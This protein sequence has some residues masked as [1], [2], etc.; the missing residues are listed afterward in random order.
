[1]A[2]VEVAPTSDEA[3]AIDITDRVAFDAVLAELRE[4]GRL[5][6]VENQP[7]RPARFAKTHEPLSPSIVEALGTEQ[8]W[9]HQAQAIDLI[10]E[11]QSVVV[12]TGT[13]SGK[14]RCYQIPIAEAADRPHHT[15]TALL[16]YPTKAL[17]QDQLRAMA[18][19]KFPG[20][21]AG[22][23]DGDS[24]PEQRSWVRASANVIMTNP[25]ML[26][27]GLL[28]S[29]SRWATFFGRLEHVVIDELH[30]LRGIF[31]THVSHV[32]RRLRRICQ[33]YGSDPTFIFT[34]ATIGAP[35]V[36]ASELC[37]K[38]VQAVTADG[39][40]CGERTIALLNP[41][42]L[43]EARG[44]RT[45]ANA[46]TAS[47]AADLMRSGH[48]TIVFCRSR[49]GTELVTG[50][51]ASRLPADL[52]DAV[53]AYRSGYLAEER[54]TIEH[55]LFDGTL[56]GVVATSALELGVDIGGLDACVLNTFPGTVASMWQQMGRAGRGQQRSAAILVAGDDQLD[57][58]MMANPTDLL[59][60]EPER[61]VINPANPF[62]LGPHLACAAFEKPISHADDEYWG[63]ALDDGIRDLVLDDTITLK[64][65]GT[66]EPVAVYTGSGRPSRGI[67]LRSGSAD[68]YRIAD[69]EGV[70]IGTVDAERAF[71]VVHPGA[72]YLHQGRPYRVTDLDTG[73]RVATVTEADGDEY[74]QARTRVD[75][76]VLE[77]DDSAMLGPASVHLGAVE[78]TSQ[79]TGYQR[80]EVR[81][82]RI[83]SNE[84]LDLPPSTLRTRAFWYVV[85]PQ[86]IEV[87]DI[88]HSAIPGA[89][90]AAEH[91][92]IGMLPLFTI[93]DRWDVGG[94]S[95][96]WHAGT[97]G[98]TIFI[99]DAHPGGSGIAELG[100]A[101]RDRHFLATR[102]AVRSCGCADGCPS[103]VQ[104]PKCG[105]GNEPLDKAGA[106]ALL[107][108][109]L[110]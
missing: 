98:P 28:P 58:W 76:A 41:P 33:H 2:L 52:S 64:P 36:L 45:S 77:A 12:A 29:H 55:E 82:R 19:Y 92:A 23:Y 108:E 102:D 9:T 73:N 47:V 50:D 56:R 46:E 14:S 70:L 38:E 97:G 80:R 104:S 20:V 83:L 37:G 30:V 10:R 86:T 62:V 42:L 90:H 99:Y 32:L 1:M 74:T 60:R 17:A 109:I 39:S 107:D 22:T 105:N 88:D 59:T 25:E 91:A 40:P 69:A 35:E 78:V 5:A 95:T 72:V 84:A 96:A 15:A 11:Q 66:G 100:F 18:A 93:C 87:A 106:V 67:G 101:E 81:S 6:H 34:S 85:P 27:A 26:H 4:D 24:T 53:R 65:S 21:V 13:A 61:A 43:D 89:L 63:D 54:R 68:E 48:R 103:C 79:V 31:G 7:A 71:S 16:L 49:K 51:I 94:V 44:L 110:H 8:L 75:I 57:Q 3:V